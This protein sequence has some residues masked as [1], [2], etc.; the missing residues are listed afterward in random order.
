MKIALVR[1]SFGSRSLI[2]PRIKG[3]AISTVALIQ[4]SHSDSS[5]DIR[6]AC[7]GENNSVLVSVE[8][9]SLNRLGEAMRWL[10]IDSTLCKE[11]VSA[12]W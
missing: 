7:R 12:R 8:K 2:V 6:F 3:P 1:R 10:P 4:D 5:H 9:T 11:S